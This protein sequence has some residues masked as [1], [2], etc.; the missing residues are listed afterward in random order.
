MG[1]VRGCKNE[2]DLKLFHPQCVLAS[3]MPDGPP[4]EGGPHPPASCECPLC[5]TFRKVAGLV[6]G[7]N[8]T[9]ALRDRVR[10]YIEGLYT[11]LLEIALEVRGPPA[12]VCEGAGLSGAV[13]PEGPTSPPPA[14]EPAR[15]SEGRGDP[16]QAEE[17]PGQAG[18]KVEKED[19]SPE[20]VVGE[21]KALPV[22]PTTRAPG[23]GDGE[24]ATSASSRP[25]VEADENEETESKRKKRPPLPRQRRGGYD[26]RDSSRGRR[27]R[28]SSRRRRREAS[29]TPS[30]HELHAKAAPSSKR[31]R[32]PS[33]SPPSVHTPEDKSSPGGEPRS[34]LARFE[35]TSLEVAE[36]E[37]RKEDTP[38]TL[39]AEEE[40]EEAV[41]LPEEEA[42]ELEL[43]E[44]ESPAKKGKAKG[45]GKG[46]KG[47]KG[48][49]SKPKKKN[50]GLKKTWRNIDFYANKRRDPTWRRNAP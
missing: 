23:E 50:R 40:S 34:S 11:Q 26:R 19:E 21:K 1:H 42:P 27:R 14:G 22:R 17:A 18:V 45:K 8:S 5:R 13:R 20:E 6:F 30:R 24:G 41:E 49:K 44:S 10:P 36:E 28:E 35:G 33:R 2:T 47:K 39:P 31:P 9:Q 46:F 37:P 48:T 12:R 29:R 32:T 38:H 7:A 25:E 4:G 15:D 43:P 16:K 3:A